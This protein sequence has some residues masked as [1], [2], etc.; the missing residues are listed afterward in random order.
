[1][2]SRLRETVGGDLYGLLCRSGLPP[3]VSVSRI[4]TLTSPRWNR[5]AFRIEL[6]D[7]SS[8]KGR[9]FESNEAAERVTCL[10]RYLPSKSFPRIIAHQGLA[11]LSEWID[12]DVLSSC[13]ITHRMLRQAGEI[14]RAIHDV[15]LPQSIPVAL[16]LK[17][18]RWR[19][20]LAAKAETL[21]CAG[22]LS[23]S[24]RARALELADTHAPAS[25]RSGLVHGD[26]CP[27]NLVV[28]A[29]GNLQVID[30]DSI[31]L[32]T[33][34]YDLA[35]VWYRWPMA[36]DERRAFDDGYGDRDVLASYQKESPCWA[37]VVLIGA[38]EFRFRNQLPDV[39]TPLRRLRE[40][41]NGQ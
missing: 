23:S 38:A 9:R 8:C 33:R 22:L 30:H 10:A 25:V 18:E 13:P 16:R 34:E 11:E 36:L 12:G 1:M 28:D 24:E 40:I 41:L 15:A 20:L 21:Q 19:D 32:R 3:V 37:V 31:A 7:G 4:S 2:D 35:R 39:E 26:L 5:A 17:G 29:A 6:S 27:E 14:A